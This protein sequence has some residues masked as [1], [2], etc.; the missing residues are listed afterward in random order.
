MTTKTKQI[1]SIPSK[2]NVRVIW[3]DAPENYT[4]G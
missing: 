4:Q 1:V 2:A 3:E